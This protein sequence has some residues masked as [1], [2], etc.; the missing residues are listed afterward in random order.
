MLH[1]LLQPLSELAQDM[2]FESVVG[3]HFY[4]FDSLSKFARICQR[5]QA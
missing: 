2:V 5:W 4:P 3:S 1:Q